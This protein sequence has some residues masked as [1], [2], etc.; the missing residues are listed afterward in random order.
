MA[1]SL[2]I[3]LRQAQRILRELEAEGLVTRSGRGRGT[4]WS[5]IRDN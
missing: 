4:V 5:A 3:G 1:E 2:G